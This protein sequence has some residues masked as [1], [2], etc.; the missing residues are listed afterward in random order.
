MSIIVIWLSRRC[1][2]WSKDLMVSKLESK[3]QALHWIR[4]HNWYSTED[5]VTVQPLFAKVLFLINSN[6]PFNFGNV[7]FDLTVKN[8]DVFWKCHAL[9]F[10]FLIHHVLTSLDYNLVEQDGVFTSLPI[11]NEQTYPVLKSFSVVGDQDEDTQTK[12]SLLDFH[13]LFWASTIRTT[14]QCLDDQR[15][16]TLGVFITLDLFTLY[17]L[18]LLVLIFI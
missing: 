8:E 1:S 5:Y 13:C 3:Y 11:Y 9:L 6:I 15:K 4:A 10:L 12:N 14:L 17:H 18:C 7:A 2:S 16:M